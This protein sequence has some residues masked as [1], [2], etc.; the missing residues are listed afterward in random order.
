MVYGQNETRSVGN[1]FE[2]VSRKVHSVSLNIYMKR[3]RNLVR[4]S[5]AADQPDD[6]KQDDGSKQRDQQGWDRDCVIDC[7]DI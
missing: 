2:F 6:R 3:K 4:L 1:W 5:S 7:P